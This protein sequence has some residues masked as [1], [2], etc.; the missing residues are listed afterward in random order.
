M[1]Q[2]SQLLPTPGRTDQ[3]EI[4]VGVDPFPL[5]ELQEQ[6]A[7]EPTGG[8]IVDVFDARLLA[9]FGGAQPGRQAFVPPP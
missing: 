7:I 9:Q 4:V 8:A 1:A 2:A 3:G 5:R 6:G